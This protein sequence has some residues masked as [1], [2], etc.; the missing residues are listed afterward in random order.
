MWNHYV[1][2]VP[3][4]TNRLEAWHET[5]KKKI[6]LNIH[7]IIQAFK[8]IQATHYY[9]DRQ[10]DCSD[11]VPENTSTSIADYIHSIDIITY[12]DDASPPLPFRM[13][14]VHLRS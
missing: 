12:A 10:D 6:H 9:N 2:R 3:C 7:T 4:T 5:L 14:N 11:H 8:D 1:T 13:N